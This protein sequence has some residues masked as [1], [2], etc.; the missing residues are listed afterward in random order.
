LFSVLFSAVP[1]MLKENNGLF[2]TIE[3]ELSL[4]TQEKTTES[5]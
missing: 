4:R 1:P 5:T 3:V 2:F